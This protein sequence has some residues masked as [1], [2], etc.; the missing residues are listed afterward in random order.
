MSNSNSLFCVTCTVWN[1]KF[2]SVFHVAGVVSRIQPGNNFDAPSSLTII[3]R[4]VHVSCHILKQLVNEAALLVR[5]LIELL[6]EVQ[7]DLVGTWRELGVSRPGI[8]GF[9][10]GVGVVLLLVLGVNF[11]HV[12]E[13]DGNHHVH[14]HDVAH[15]DVRD[16]EN[17]AARALVHQ[18]PRHRGRPALPRQHL[19]HGEEG[20]GEVGKVPA[21][22]HVRVEANSEDGVDACDQHQDAEGVAAPR[23]GFF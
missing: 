20:G 6:Q 21:L 3:C 15:Q 8:S 2:H 14:E 12:F 19:K 17:R 23:D 13:E 9:P 16:E 22:V 18:R 5:H 11:V 4:V 10:P 7:H 1:G